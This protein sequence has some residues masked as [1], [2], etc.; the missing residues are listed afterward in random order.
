MEGM[1][2]RR[3]ERGGV[4]RSP[5]LAAQ[6]RLGGTTVSEALSS[7]KPVPSAET[8]VAMARVLRLPEGELLELR[9][10]A[11]EEA[12]T[13]ARGGP[14]RPIGEWDPHALE[15]HPAG[16]VRSG[17]PGQR[18]LSGYVPREHD[19]ILAGA[20]REVK[21]GHSRMLVLVGESSTGKK[22]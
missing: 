8:V 18:L 9:R 12:V 1:G 6:A 5:Q 3:T 13:A 11:V 19:R 20:V 10:T 16:A 7:R 4:A 15:V 21:R 2:R 22:S 17:L 14:G